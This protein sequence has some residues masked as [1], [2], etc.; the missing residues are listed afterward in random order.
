MRAPASAEGPPN[1]PI[2]RT[3]LLLMSRFVSSQKRAYLLITHPWFQI[4][5]INWN[6]NILSAR[7]LLGLLPRPPGGGAASWIG[8]C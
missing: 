7:S 3:G 6:E 2:R 4:F 5:I 1:D 8:Y